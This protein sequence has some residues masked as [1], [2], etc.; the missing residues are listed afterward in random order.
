VAHC[1]CLGGGRDKQGYGGS[2]SGPGRYFMAIWSAFKVRCGLS[3][4]CLGGG[5]TLRTM[6]GVSDQA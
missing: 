1:T 4:A 3:R 6:P 5:W 2:I